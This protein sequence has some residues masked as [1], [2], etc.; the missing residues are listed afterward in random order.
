MFDIIEDKVLDSLLSLLTA[1]AFFF[2][3]SNF[4]VVISFKKNRVWMTK[5]TNRKKMSYIA[6]YKQFFLLT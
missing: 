3:A 5:R 1:I 4:Q 6:L 2:F